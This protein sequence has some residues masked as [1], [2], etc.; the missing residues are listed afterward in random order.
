MVWGIFVKKILLASA[1]FAALTS[2]S[3][4]AD[5]PSPAEVD[6]WSGFHAGIIGGFGWTETSF[7]DDDN[8]GSYDSEGG[9]AGLFAGYDWQ[10]GNIVFGVDASI[11]YLFDGEVEELLAP[12]TAL[13]ADSD[14]FAT[15][16]GRVGYAF[17]N[18][19]VYAAGGAAFQDAQTTV[20]ALGPDVAV[21]A[22]ETLVGWTI[23]AGV[24]AKIAE[25]WSFRVEYLYARFEDQEFTYDFTPVGG[26][27]VVSE[28]DIENH[29]IRGGIAYHF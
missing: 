2:A 28:S 10:A 24:D 11:S 19:L 9:G 22:D 16:R 27:L 15:V 13:E 23:G 14:W 8:S 20:I 26:N 18:F 3:S 7:D 12:G 6:I 17:D 5:L 1:A 4:A 29:T 21:D 25:N